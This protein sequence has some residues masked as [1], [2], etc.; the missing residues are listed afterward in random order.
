MLHTGQG[1]LVMYAGPS[2]TFSDHI[3]RVNDW[4]HGVRQAQPDKDTQNLLTSEPLTTAERLRLIHHLITAPRSEGGA[5][6]TPA[7][8]EWKNVDKI[9]ALHDPIHDKAWLKEWSGK[10]FLT[11]RDLDLLRD[12]VGERV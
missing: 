4:L 11:P 2:V 3:Y 1:T 5:D 6:I 12:N 9:F 7:H 8:E 10:T